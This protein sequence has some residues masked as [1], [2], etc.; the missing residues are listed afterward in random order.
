MEQ[1]KTLFNYLYDDIVEQITSGKLAFGEILP[2]YKTLCGVYNVGIR[3]VRDVIKKLIKD[4]YIKSVA[5]SHIEVAYKDDSSLRN[6]E[7]VKALLAKRDAIT[8]LMKTMSYLL[9]YAATEASKLVDKQLI[10]ANRKDIRGLDNMEARQQWR[11]VSSALQRIFSVFNN[12]LFRDLYIDVNLF[13]QI[14]VIDG[15]E[16]PFS[17]ITTN[18]EQRLNKLYDKFLY[19]DMAGIQRVISRMYLN[20]TQPVSVYFDTLAEKYPD[21]KVTQED[22]HWNAQ[23]GRSNRYTEIARDLLEKIGRGT[24]PDGT[25][26]PTSTV[27]QEEYGVSTL[28]LINA[29]DALSSV[30]VIEKRSQRGRYVVTTNNAHKKEPFI[31]NGA[32]Q[33]DAATLLGAIH[34]VVLV[35]RGIT[36]AGFDYLTESDIDELENEINA[37]DTVRP[38]YSILRKLAM[39][40]PLKPLQDIYTQLEHLMNW[41]YYA[42]FSKKCESN[43]ETIAAKKKIAIG[44]IRSGNKEALADMLRDIYSFSFRNMQAALVKYGVPEAAEM[45]L[46]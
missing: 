7:P 36:Y 6:A 13:S 21:I 5:R 41:G 39:A 20:A 45:K 3:T 14:A 24:Y 8:D 42:R 33:N 32:P 30:G 31:R 16:N 15:F 29:L 28:T 22:Y 1:K 40:Q 27:L 35:C 43:L 44:Y 37:P 19:Q 23:K 12:S 18:A 2:S 25:Y 10:D 38:S 34:A 17:G 26:L 9:P 46:P 11:A 4:E